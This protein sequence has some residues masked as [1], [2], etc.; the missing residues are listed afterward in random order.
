MLDR[1]A[2]EAALW[3]AIVV[4]FFVVLPARLAG[5]L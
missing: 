2:M 3:A 5:L 1:Y 4:V